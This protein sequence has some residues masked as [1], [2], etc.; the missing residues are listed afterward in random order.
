M[1]VLTLMAPDMLVH[2]VVEVETQ[3]EAPL[4]AGQH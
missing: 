3:V 4:L 2:Q 1:A